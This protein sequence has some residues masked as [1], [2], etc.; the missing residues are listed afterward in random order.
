MTISKEIREKSYYVYL[1]RCEDN[2]LYTGIAKDVIKRFEEH[3]SG[4]GAKY[5]KAKKVK[6]IFFYF[7]CE[8]KSSALKVENYIK[9]LRK[10]KKENLKDEFFQFQREIEVKLGLKITGLRKK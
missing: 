4:N 7:S 5:T 9:K 8:N 10:E 2:S 1:L 3:F 6:E